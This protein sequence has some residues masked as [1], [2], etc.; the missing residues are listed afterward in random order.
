[1]IVA[2]GGTGGH[3]FPGLAVAEA[4]TARG[5][6]QVLF[7]GSAYG[8]EA[9]TVPQTQFPFRALAIRGLRGRGWRGVLEFGWQL[10]GALLQAW[11]IVGTFRPT[12]VLG[13]GGYSS[14]PPVLVAWLRRVPSVLLEQNV[15]GVTRPG[16]T[17]GKVCVRTAV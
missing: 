16:K 2:G 10:P 3:L 17:W 13:L 8:I 1:M 6:T 12:V 7:V 5:D 11:R 4:L 15:Q 9:R 14:V